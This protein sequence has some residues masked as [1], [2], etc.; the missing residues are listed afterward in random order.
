MRSAPSLAYDI[1]SEAADIGSQEPLPDVV[2]RTCPLQTCQTCRRF[3]E[4]WVLGLIFV[5]QMKN[6][7]IGACL[8]IRAYSA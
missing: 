6:E 1:G 5:L 2:V 3:K 7:Y 4:I 8:L